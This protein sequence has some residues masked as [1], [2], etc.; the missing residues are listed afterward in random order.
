MALW[1]GKW[2]YNPI[3]GVITLLTT[4]RG[5]HCNYSIWYAAAVAWLLAHFIAL[6][7]NMPE[8][9]QISEIPNLTTKT[10]RKIKIE[11]QI[12]EHEITSNLSK[13]Q[14]KNCQ[15][16]KIHHKE[17]TKPTFEADHGPHGPIRLQARWPKPL[18]SFWF[19]GDFTSQVY[20]DCNEY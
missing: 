15:P 10:S 7:L 20:R 14:Q 4:G 13:S 11:I 18:W 9:L 16:K 3:S 2:G 19:L 5:L 6:L 1:M 12:G 8:L 17:G